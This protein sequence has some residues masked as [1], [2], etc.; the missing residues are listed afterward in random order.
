ME[1]FLYP[2]HPNRCIMTGPGNVGKTVPLTN[3][4]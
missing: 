4:S 2:T 3:Y 1:K